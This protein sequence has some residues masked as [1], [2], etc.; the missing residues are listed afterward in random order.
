MEKSNN[1]LYFQGVNGPAQR[2]RKQVDLMSQVVK[3][4]QKEELKIQRYHPA[5]LEEKN[6]PKVLEGKRQR[7][8]GKRQGMKNPPVVKTEEEREVSDK[9]LSHLILAKYDVENSRLL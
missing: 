6:L 4:E 9:Y 8:A 2:W 3:T 1:K 7:K 5:H